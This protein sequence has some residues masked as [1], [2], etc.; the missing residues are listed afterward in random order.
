MHLA[1]A[2]SSSY[3]NLQSVKIG[4]VDVTPDRT[5]EMEQL[6]M[7]EAAFAESGVQLTWGEDFTGRYLYTVIPGG[8]PGMTIA[9]VNTTAPGG[10]PGTTVVH[11]PTV[12]DSV[13][14]SCR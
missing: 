9:H 4:L 14:S 6:P 12:G 1:A 7:V 2:A 5:T 8:P 13:R 11:V 10:E 3:P